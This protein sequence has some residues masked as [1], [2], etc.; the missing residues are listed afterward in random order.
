MEAAD[1]SDT[2]FTRADLHCRADRSRF[3]TD[4]A[5]ALLLDERRLS[6]AARREG[7]TQMDRSSS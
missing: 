7:Q 1:H 4:L 6:T 3:L 5:S 2:A